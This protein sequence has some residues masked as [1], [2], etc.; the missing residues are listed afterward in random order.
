MYSFDCYG[1]AELVW[2]SYCFLK[3][4]FMVVFFS[5]CFKLSKVYV[6]VSAIVLLNKMP[7]SGVDVCCV[8]VDR[9]VWLSKTI[10]A[11]L[12]GSSTLNDALENGQ[13]VCE[14]QIMSVIMYSQ[15]KSSKKKEKKGRSTYI[16]LYIYF[17]I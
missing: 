1:V 11:V 12:S 5:Q 6:C 15:K 4:V 2:V 17:Y 7:C 16:Y 8:L 13:H 3:H 9:V 14:K 10:Y